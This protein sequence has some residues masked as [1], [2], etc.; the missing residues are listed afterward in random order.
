MTL[1]KQLIAGISFLFLLIFIGTLGISVYNIRSYFTSQLESHAQDTA[2]SLGLSLR[3]H[4]AKND[5]PMMNSMVDAIFDRG[6][7]QEITVTRADGEKIITRYSKMTIENVP[8]WFVAI[9]RL[10]PPQRES[11]VTTGW[12]RGATVTVRSHPGYAYYKLWRNTVDTF[13]WFLIMLVLAIAVAIVMTKMVLLPLKDVEK[14][15]TAISKRNFPEPA[16]LPRTRELRRV[17]T[18]MNNMT[19]KIKRIIEEQTDLAEK[20]RH[21]AYT[22][23]VTKLRNRRGFDM[24]LEHMVS[25]KDEVAYGALFI[26]RVSD[27]TEYNNRFG[28]SEGDNLLKSVAFTIQS[29]SVNIQNASIGRLGGAEFGILAPN[30]TLEE[31]EALGV[32]ISEGL[33][34]SKFEGMERG[35]GHVGIGYYKTDLTV[36]KLLA[37]AD[38]ALRQAQRKGPNTWSLYDREILREKEIRGAREWKDFIGKVIDTRRIFFLYQPIKSCDG[39]TTLHYEALARIQAEDRSYI[40][41]AVF[42]PMVDRLGMT[43][44]IDKLLVEK[45]IGHINAQP[46]SKDIFS[47]NLFASSAFN[48]DFVDWLCQTLKNDYDAASRLVFEVS[49]YGAIYNIDAFKTFVDK[50]VDIGAKVTID[51]FGVSSTSF[52]FLRDL[53][54]E[55]IKIDGSY[56][57]DLDK[58]KDNQF[59]VQ[60]ISEIGHGLDITM[61]AKSVES[62]K[63]LKALSGLHVDGAQGYYIGRPEEPEED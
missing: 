10:E 51:N 38:M 28:Y 7:Y 31:A 27:F 63:A 25:S 3:P 60:A 26:I 46:H 5:L 41:A 59:F 30:M 44:E 33:A 11:I 23:P 21:E 62:E 52:G 50:V 1:S 34:R 18:A 17:V 45:V 53:K 35:T 32:K 16:K 15:A 54:L 12:K 20:L 6:F 48:S 9:I 55:Y 58:N 49:E 56:I 8:E 4:L 13:Q 40:P 61:V 37:E 29:E 42:M 47:L 2:T 24:R 22:D 39:V 19:L 57:L 36:E 43:I 14:Q